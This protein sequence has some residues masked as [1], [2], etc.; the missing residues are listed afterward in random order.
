MKK[1]NLL[2][3]MLHAVLANGSSS[4]MF[5]AFDPKAPVTILSIF[6][7]DPASFIKPAQRK[8]NT[9]KSNARRIRN[10]RAK[11]ARRITRLRA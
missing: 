2:Q 1:L 10:K 6:G 8:R 3:S 5:Q 4:N 11:Q 7:F 9:A